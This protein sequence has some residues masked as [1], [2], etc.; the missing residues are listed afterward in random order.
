[1]QE[2][3]EYW[4]R[5]GRRCQSLACAVLGHG[6]TRHPLERA[7][8][9]KRDVDTWI[10]VNLDAIADL[11]ES[12]RHELRHTASRAWVRLQRHQL[13]HREQNGALLSLGA[14]VS[15]PYLIAWGSIA[16]IYGDLENHQFPNLYVTFMGLAAAGFTLYVSTHPFVVISW[17]TILIRRTL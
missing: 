11:R 15:I 2:F 8:Q 17:I 13:T 3:R 4:K 14:L 10:T 12:E 16:S 6:K 5:I 9:L 1:R 7:A